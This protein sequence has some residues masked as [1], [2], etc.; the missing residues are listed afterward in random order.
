M[1]STIKMPA[2]AAYM[3]ARR[4]GCTVS[5]E[6]KRLYTR[7]EISQAF[8]KACNDQDAIGVVF[9][10]HPDRVEEFMRGGVSLTLY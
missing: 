3:I 7:R 10:L 2:M 9:C 6:F 5:Q 8:E 4:V 1:S